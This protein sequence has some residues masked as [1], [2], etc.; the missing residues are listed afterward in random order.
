[1]NSQPG[2]DVE[3]GHRAGFVAIAGRPN[4]GKS[5]LLNRLVGQKVGITSSRPQTTR[6][7]VTGIVTRPGFQIAF[8]DTPGYQTRHRSPLNRAM[9]RAVGASLLDAN[10]IV[11]VVEALKFGRGDE[12]IAPL[13]PQHV[14]VVLAINKIDLVPRKDQLLPFIKEIASRRPFAAVVPVSA[15]K[16]FQID[17]LLNELASVLPEG[18]RLFDEDE[19]TTANER[20][21]AGELLQ[22]K[23]FRLLGEELPYAT[24][25]QIDE[26]KIVG[27]VR[28]IHGVVL[29][30]KP[31]QKGIVIGRDGQKLKEI[32][33][34]ARHDMERLFGGRVFL[35]LWVRVKRGWARTETSLRRVGFES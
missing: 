6:H 23:L 9:N 11:W 33:T 3:S 13:L 2:L 20:F 28:H 18:P 22:E 15:R 30:D 5:T 27:D 32:A 24:I 21:L 34:Q 16:E 29:V 10:A 17:A 35:E 12:A 19:I 14:P 7:A 4:V 25:V 1:M 8:I 26:F 31:S